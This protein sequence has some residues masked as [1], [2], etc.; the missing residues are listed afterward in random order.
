M[1]R[2]RRAARTRCYREAV[3]KTPRY[4]DGHK[5]PTG[6]RKA[7][8]TD[9]RLTFRRERERIKTATEQ[10]AKDESERQEKVRAMKGRK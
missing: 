1:R 9:V 2:L 6:Y 7:A 5:Y 10:A 3:V 4:T 8:S